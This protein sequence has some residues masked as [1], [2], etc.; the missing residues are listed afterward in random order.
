MIGTCE[1]NMSCPVC[2]FGWGCSPDPCD[3]IVSEIVGN[4]K[5]ALMKLGKEEHFFG[6]NIR[7]AVKSIRGK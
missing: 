7:D 4:R 6:D 1:H 3:D 5:E 2:G